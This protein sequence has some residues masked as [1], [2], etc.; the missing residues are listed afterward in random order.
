MYD[1][2]YQVL[3]SQLSDQIKHLTC[4]ILKE[5][6][7]KYAELKQEEI[8]IDQNFKIWLAKPVKDLIKLSLEVSEKNTSTDNILEKIAIKTHN[9]HFQIK[10]HDNAI[11]FARVDARE[12]KDNWSLTELF[13]SD[14]ARKIDES[15][16]QLKNKNVNVNNIDLVI[17]SELRIYT[18]CLKPVKQ[19]IQFYIIDSDNWYEKGK[20]LNLN[21]FIQ[22][23]KAFTTIEKNILNRRKNKIVKTAMLS[24]YS[25]GVSMNIVGFSIAL[26]GEP[27]LGFPTAAC[28]FSF[29]AA[30]FFL[31]KISKDADENYSRLKGS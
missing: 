6:N 30:A 16:N 15:F 2:N 22:S 23:I 26:L 24:L 9:L 4:E 28:G 14:L 25:L 20:P 7:T 3:P 19:D 13:V 11:G 27:N 17:I 10:Y 5:E 29:D 12:L 8:K 21:A 18:F 31:K 1:I